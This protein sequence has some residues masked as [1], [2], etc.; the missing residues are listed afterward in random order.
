MRHRSRLICAVLLMS[1]LV[2]TAK[3]KKKVLLPA[4]IV[5][6]STAWVIIDPDVGVDV[7]DP[8]ANNLARNAV[9]NAL[10]KWGRLKPVA[11]PSLADLVIVV[12]KGNGRI[13]EP[14]IAGTP[15]N[16]PPPMIGQRTDSG[17]NASARTGSPPP[18]GESDPRGQSDPHPQMEVG[19]PQDNFAVY[20][21]NRMHDTGNPLNSPAVW[22]YSAPNALD[23]PTV[24]AVE[25]FRKIMLESEKQLSKP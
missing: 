25:E 10:A 6:A 8:N 21:C 7:R 14:T 5:Q 23:P 9:E 3:N 11:D 19:D 15:V 18:F 1:C 2:A 13:A 24:P 4:D 12:R 20:R 16:T 17:V 22:R